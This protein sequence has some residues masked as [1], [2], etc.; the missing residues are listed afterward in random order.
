MNIEEY[1]AQTLAQLEELYQAMDN[2]A[3]SVH[4]RDLGQS[5]QFRHENCTDALACYLKGVK[6]ISTLN[7][8]V[9]LLRVGY[10]QEIGA[11]CR[12]V[13]DFCNEILFLVSRDADDKLSDDQMLF[14]KNFYQD[15]FD[16]PSDPLRSTQKRDT[17]ATNKIFATFGRFAEGGLNPSDAQ[18]LVRTVHQ[19]LSGYVHGAYPQI[20]E[21]Y[22]GSP[23]HF[24]TSGMLGT[25]Q[26]DFWR[27]KL[28]TYVERL[29]MASVFVT[30]KLGAHEQEAPIQALLE[31]FREHIGINNEQKP[32][33]ML[34]QYKQQRKTRTG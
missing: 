14:L 25:P 23:P 12:M 20:M 19:Y 24:H 21:M 1:L 9:A 6:A 3:G 31:E 28:I 10:T 7:A 29:I 34:E 4:V 30:K 15:E 27:K 18:E 26:I 5:W 13:D 2:A 11:L 8:C 33:E 16:R 17:V 32:I 22:G